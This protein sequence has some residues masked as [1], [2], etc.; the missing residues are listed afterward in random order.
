MSKAKDIINIF[1]QDDDEGGEMGC[2]FAIITPDEF[3]IEDNFRDRRGKKPDEKEWEQINK[4]VAT[5]EKNALAYLK[6]VIGEVR[7]EGHGGPDMA[8]GGSCWCRWS[9]NKGLELIYTNRD[10][11]GHQDLSSEEDS[12]IFKGVSEVGL[13]ALDASIEFF[14]IEPE[15]L[16]RL[17]GMF[18]G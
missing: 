7:D 18:G 17:E 15:D 2:G 6:K 11:E 8:L 16:E 10:E 3:V 13:D 9:N 14:S 5:I 1:E 12:A 4:D